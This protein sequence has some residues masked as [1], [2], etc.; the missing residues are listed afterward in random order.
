M[1]DS[2]EVEGEDSVDG[3]EEVEGEDSVDGSE[4]VEEEGLVGSFGRL[5]QDLNDSQLF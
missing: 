4:K 3:S 1:D 2:K 5:V